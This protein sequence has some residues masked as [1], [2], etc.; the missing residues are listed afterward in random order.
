MDKH[1]QKLCGEFTPP[2]VFSLFYTGIRISTRANAHIF[3]PIRWKQRRFRPDIDFARKMYMESTYLPCYTQK[4]DDFVL[5]LFGRSTLN[6]VEQLADRLYRIGVPLPNNPLKELN[7]YLIRGEERELLIDTGFRCD[8]CRA[9]LEEGLRRLGSCSNRRDVAITH[10]HADH[11]GMADQF[12]APC[13]HVYM[14]APDLSYLQEYFKG[15][16]RRSRELRFIREGFPTE[17]LIDIF[18]KNPAEQMSLQRIDHRFVP[19]RDGECITVG[20]YRLQTILVPGHTPGN[21]ML[22]SKEQGIMFTSDHILF[23]ISP[24]IT[25]WEQCADPLGDYLESLRRVE[26][27]PVRLAL[28]GHRKSGDYHARIRALLSHHAARLSEIQRIISAEEGL[29]AYKIAGNMTWN[30]R[31]RD[32]ESFPRVQKWFAVGECMAHLDHLVLR[33]AIQRYEAD[34]FVRYAGCE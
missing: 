31:A 10:L 17:E 21:A 18:P 32:W 16:L 20:S 25:A 9:A 7:S 29:T 34:G 12:A 30:I 6:M 22:W 33:G 28:P 2:E 4:H 19:L 23:D 11:C 26:C 13:G 27:Y 15:E 5:I 24:N 3:L 1:S 14:P 8:V